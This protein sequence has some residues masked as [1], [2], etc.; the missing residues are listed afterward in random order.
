[1][2]VLSILALSEVAV[3][4]PR[5]AHQG[6]LVDVSGAPVHGEHDVVVSLY[7]S[8]SAPIALWSKTYADLPIDDGYYTAILELDDEA[9]PIDPAWLGAGAWVG[10]AVS[11]TPVGGRTPLVDAPVA[12]VARAVASDATAGACAAGAI[13][14]NAGTFQGC[15]S[16][17]WYDLFGSP[18][19]VSTL[20]STSGPP[21]GGGTVTL[22]GRGFLPG[23]AVHFG[24][25][26]SPLVTVAGDTSLTATVPAGTAGVTSDV[27]VTNP[28]GRFGF[29][30]R[31]QYGGRRFF[32]LTLTNGT[33]GNSTISVSELQLYDD[34][35]GA[36][37]TNN[38]TSTATP[39]PKTVSWTATSYTDSLGWEVFDGISSNGAYSAGYMTS[40]ANSAVTIDFG[41]GNFYR[42][43]KYRIWTSS[44]GD[45]GG[46]Y[47]PSAWTL[48]S[49]LD[50]STWT[51]IDTRSGTPVPSGT[52]LE[53]TVSPVL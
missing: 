5:L 33:S 45:S 34:I 52:Y 50:G 28:D 32:R 49:S 17:A 22:T 19:V 26:A 24:G 23:A 10:V 53:F 51:T 20:S 8:S 6:R 12:A 44:Y 38:M 29:A 25:T 2:W 14:H 47:R 15:K 35:A 42:V 46:T 43:S 16:G 31:Y 9:D 41:P 27:F 30:G 7:A 36:F 39:A 1:M 13:R 3:A 48:E 11:G 21:S 18:P 37:I 4:G 40:S